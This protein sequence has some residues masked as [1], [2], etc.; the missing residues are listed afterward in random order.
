VLF[1]DEMPEFSRHA[2][3]VLR[4]PLED[5]LA[6][7]SR[8]QRTAVFP[9]RFVL[10]GA[11]NPCPVRLSWRRAARVPLHAVAE[12][13]ATRRACPGPLRDRIDLTVPVSALP[14][15]EL[16]SAVE[17]EQTAAIRARVEQARLRQAARDP[18]AGATIN[19]R[20]SPRALR[21][22]CAL[23]GRTERLLLD[24]A[25]RLGLTARSFDRILRVSRTIADLR[26]SERVEFDDVAEALQFRG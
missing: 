4:Q 22:V 3:E 17:A 20:L 16:A 18:A 23:D 13:I 9:A 19:A 8:A 26:S 1:L 15:V 2:L 5:G 6:R 21:R 10:V 24:A 7:V 14:T 25:E 11:M 12:S